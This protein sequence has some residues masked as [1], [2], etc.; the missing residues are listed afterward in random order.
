MWRALSS[1]DEIDLHIFAT[2]MHAG[3]S[4][5]L[6]VPGRAVYH[7]GGADIAGQTGK[8][9][10]RSMAACAIAAS[11]VIGAHDFDCVLVMGDR[12]DMLPAAFAALPYNVPIAHIHGGELTLGAIDDRIRH[13]LT[14]LSHLHFVSSVEAAARLARMGEEPWRIA[15]TGAPG[16]EALMEAPLL[17]RSE[18]ASKVGL[19][20]KGDFL[21]VT[22]HPETNSEAP[23]A[24]MRA[25][26]AALE[27]LDVPVL[28]TA[29]NSDPGGLKVRQMLDAWLAD[30]PQAVFRDTLG[31]TLYAN[32]LRHAAAMVGNSSSGLIEAGIF[33][34]PVVD[35]GERQAGRTAGSNV[36]HVRNDARDIASAVAGFLPSGKRFPK[37]SS[38]GDGHASAR[39]ADVLARLPARPDLLNKLFYDGGTPSFETPWKESDNAETEWSIR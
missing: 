22:V 33:G 9:A 1:R 3:S 19:P 30:H 36:T 8:A 15:I 26:L 20:Q 32:A 6:P 10:A 17:S 11:D 28:I 27:N 4:Q 37:S 2:G 23:D 16:L 12:L 39:I 24:P 13:A 38:Y 25:V 18:F 29:P 7:R 5:D 34:L 35:V 14:K 31:A 21:L